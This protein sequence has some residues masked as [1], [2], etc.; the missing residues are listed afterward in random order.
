MDGFMALDFPVDAR[1]NGSA[2][3]TP[4]ST[5]P[6]PPDVPVVKRR[7]R[8]ATHADRWT[9]VT[10]VLLDRQIVFLDRLV[11]DIRAATGAAI[12]RAHLIRALVD[13]LAATDVDLTTCRS[14]G[15]LL[16]LLADRFKRRGG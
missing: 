7:G 4:Q 6:A 3:G 5:H 2:V 10:V 1:G 15:D 11:S 12:T 16:S 14:E 9:K 13:S 8:R